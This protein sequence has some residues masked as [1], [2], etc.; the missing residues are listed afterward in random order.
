MDIKLEGAPSLDVHQANS[1]ATFAVKP[2][3]FKGLVPKMHVKQGDKVKA[4]D[5]LFADK[6][7][8]KSVLRLP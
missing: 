2:T 8:I 5:C 3:D 7:T 4:G 1:P 6:R